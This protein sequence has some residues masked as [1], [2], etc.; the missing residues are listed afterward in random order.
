MPRCASPNPAAL[1][2]GRRGALPAT[3]TPWHAARVEHLSE[4][5]LEQLKERLEHERADLRARLAVHEQEARAHDAQIE[6][7]D[8]AMQE[9]L[10]TESALV[11]GRERTRLGEVEAA[12]QRM[13]DGD[14]GLCEE[15]DEEI[16]F[17]R[18]L[19]EPTARYTVE[20]LELIEREAKRAQQTQHDP[21][22]Y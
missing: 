18:L 7:Q 5:Q 16:P 6:V 4:A 3:P 9:Q 13:R 10:R 1:R 12:L 19:A 11:A 8:A 20:G 2:S 15:T 22:A 14:Y 21:G 17:A